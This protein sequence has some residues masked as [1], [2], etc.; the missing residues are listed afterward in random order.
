MGTGVYCPMCK[1]IVRYSKMNPHNAECPKCEENVNTRWDGET[2]VV[3][4]KHE[5]A[6]G[7]Q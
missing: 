5:Q 2:L 3:R 1:T 4:W 7:D 6:E